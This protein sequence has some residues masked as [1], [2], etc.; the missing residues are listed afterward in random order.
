VKL[1]ANKDSEAREELVGVFTDGSMN[2]EE[3][4]GGGWHVEG[5]GKGK[6]RFGKLATVWDG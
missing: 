2:E 5:R 3:K 6:E 4:V 1:Q